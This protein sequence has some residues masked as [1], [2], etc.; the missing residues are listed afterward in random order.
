MYEDFGL[1]DL[2]IESGVYGSNYAPCL[3]KGKSYNRGV[4]CHKLV[5]E[6]MFR[7]QWCSF[8]KDLTEEDAYTEDD[9]TLASIA[10]Y[11]DA[12]S[13]KQDVPHAAS[14]V[15]DNMQPILTLFEQ[16]K[17]TGRNKSLMFTFWDNTLRWY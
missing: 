5:M 11:V 17:E 1:T 16:Y 12:C 15:S 3:L 13:Q 10:S 2:L 6:A 7:L 9:A 14:D 4:C 8:I